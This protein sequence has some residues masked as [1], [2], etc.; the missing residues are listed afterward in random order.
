MGNAASSRERTGR[1]FTSFS[2][3]WRFVATLV[4]VF[5]T[6]NPTRY[7]FVQW[8]R[9]AMANGDIGAVH[10]FVGVLLVIGWTILLVAT[11]SS[12]GTLG[13]LLGAALM[14]SLVWLL[15]DLGW[16]RL[17]SRTVI[18]WIVLVCLAALLAVGLSWSYLWRRLTGQVDITDDEQ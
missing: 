16:L 10:F 4:L 9:D 5:A 15:V 13:V 11:R 18:T 7:S 3:F 8:V 14:G 12:L 17:D 6:Y 2:F 1:E